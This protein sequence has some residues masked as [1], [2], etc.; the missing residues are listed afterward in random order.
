M[1]LNNTKEQ[2]RGYKTVLF[3]KYYRHQKIKSPFLYLRMYQK[4]WSQS[5]FWANELKNKG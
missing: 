1:L 2:L 5:V 3:F 4:Q